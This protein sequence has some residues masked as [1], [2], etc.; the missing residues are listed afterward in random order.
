MSEYTTVAEAAAKIR[1]ALKAKGWSSKD[2]SVRSESYSMGTA[3]RAEIKNARVP[4][5][6]V[7]EIADKE[8]HVRYCEYSGEILSGGNR[9]VT[10]TYS[11]EARKARAAPH[12]DAVKAAALKVVSNAL[13][14]VETAPTFLIGSGPG[15]GTTFFSL[16]SDSHILIGDANEIATAIGQR[17]LAAR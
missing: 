13:I 9:F 10:V 14:E 5:A 11:D 15:G 6:L 1:A 3:I 17:V 16:W 12:V 7:K 8:S 4:I 2:V